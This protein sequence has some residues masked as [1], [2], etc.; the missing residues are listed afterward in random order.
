MRGRCVCGGWHEGKKSLP[1]TFKISFWEAVQ[2]CRG[3]KMASEN[4]ITSR[5]PL[6]GQKLE[7]F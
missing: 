3:L 1:G 6:A 4:G 5:A 7:L 2:K